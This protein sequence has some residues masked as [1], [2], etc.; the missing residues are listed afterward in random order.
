MGMEEEDLD[1]SRIDL[2]SS[3][4]AMRQAQPTS[5]LHL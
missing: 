4:V 3:A 5:A 2:G 1:E